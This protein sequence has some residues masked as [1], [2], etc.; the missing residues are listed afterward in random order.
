MLGNLLSGGL[1]SI[2]GSANS[3]ARTFVG[4]KAAKEAGFHREQMQIQRGYQAE[5]LAPEKKG[6]FNQIVDA[7]NRMVR[8]LFTYGIVAMFIWAAIDPV[9]FS[10]TVQALQIIPEL[11]WY[12]M[13]T[14]IG[15][16]F[17]GRLLEK[18]PMKVSAK[19]IQQGKEI[20]QSIVE[21]RA[22]LWEDKYEKVDTE[23]PK[24]TTN[25][26]VTE[27]QQ[28]T[29]KPKSV[30]SKTRV[31]KPK[32]KAAPKKKSSF[33]GITVEAIDEDLQ[34]NGGR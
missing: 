31:T 25:K 27:W 32:A 16:W 2:L 7:A 13:M 33:L 14:I 1:G 23:N 26:V 6:I 34:E 18:A 21:E 30:S 4:D 20:A 19:E 9:N 24:T 15:F 28:G 3:L 11:L 12:I 10:L 17:G 29:A 22:E 5:F 8:P